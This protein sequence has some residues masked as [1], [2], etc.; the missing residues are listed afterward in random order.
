MR[1][2]RELCKT[3]LALLRQGGKKGCYCERERERNKREQDEK[4]SRGLIFTIFERKRVEWVMG[5]GGGG[6]R[7]HYRVCGV[8]YVYILKDI[9]STWPWS[10]FIRLCPGLPRIARKRTDKRTR[11]GRY[12][13]LHVLFRVVVRVQPL[14]SGP[15]DF[16]ASVRRSAK[17]HGTGETVTCTDTFNAIIL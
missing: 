17:H 14:A 1:T 5:G 6:G 11:G 4:F 13:Y 3:V 15:G 16:P 8:Y 12:Y 9:L 2:A 10:R 7:R